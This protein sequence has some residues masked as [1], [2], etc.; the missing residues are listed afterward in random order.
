MIS[1][2]VILALAVVNVAAGLRYPPLLVNAAAL[3]V[4]MVVA[5]RELRHQS[6][7]GER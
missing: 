5:W 6:Q 4:L 7:P 2:V 1:F 3:V